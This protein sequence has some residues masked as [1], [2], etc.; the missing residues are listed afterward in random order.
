MVIGVTKQWVWLSLPILGGVVGN[1]LDNKE[2][3]RMT[4]FRDKS[5]LYHRVL[6]PGESPSW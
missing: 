1:Y 2:T 6:K 4:M 3:E 5:A